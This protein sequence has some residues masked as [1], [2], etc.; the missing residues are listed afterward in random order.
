MGTKDHIVSVRLTYEEHRLLLARAGKQKVSDFL[1]N[2]IAPKMN[3]YQNMPITTTYVAPATYVAPTAAGN[4]PIW[5]TYP[6]N[7]GAVSGP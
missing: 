3:I 2:L 1:R 5:F 6:Q 4:P 7:G